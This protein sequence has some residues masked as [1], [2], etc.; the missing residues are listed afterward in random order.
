MTEAEC[1]SIITRL[2]TAVAFRGGI[3]VGNNSSNTRINPQAVVCNDEI[4]V[5]LLEALAKEESIAADISVVGLTIPPAPRVYPPLTA[6]RQPWGNGARGGG[7]AASATE[8]RTEDGC[9]TS[10]VSG[11][12]RE[13][14]VSSA[15]AVRTRA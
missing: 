3:R 13:S 15:A 7:V 2:F 6:V 8:T 10:C 11:R 4:A 12:D 1:R 5:G 9:G 14:S